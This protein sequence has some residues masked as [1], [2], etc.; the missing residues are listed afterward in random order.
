[1]QK[2]SCWTLLHMHTI[3]PLASYMGKTNDD[4]AAA[5][6]WVKMIKGSCPNDEAGR[7]ICIIDFIGGA[8]PGHPYESLCK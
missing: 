6:D 7:K 1:M 4:L 2:T 5:K 8:E 3:P